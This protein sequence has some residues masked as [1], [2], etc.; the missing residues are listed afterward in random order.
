MGGISVYVRSIHHPP[1]RISGLRQDVPTQAHADKC[2]SLTVMKAPGKEEGTATLPTVK[3]PASASPF[4]AKPPLL[5]KNLQLPAI[6][7]MAGIVL[8]PF[9]KTEVF[10]V[11]D[12]YVARVSRAIPEKVLLR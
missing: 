8:T 5:A 11:N 1:L 12:T 7:R 3:N 4:D 2:E 6:L 9:A 10:T